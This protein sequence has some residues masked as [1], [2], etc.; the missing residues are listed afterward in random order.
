MIETLEQKE[1]GGWLYQRVVPLGGR[2]RKAP[3]AWLMPILIRMAPQIKARLAG[4]VMWVKED[5][6]GKLLRDWD[7]RLKP[8]LTR[9]AS[10]L[11]SVQLAVRSDDELTAHLLQ[12]FDFLKYCLD[13]HMLLNGALEYMIA[14][15]VF[16]CRELLGWNEAQAM[17]IFGG[18]SDTSSAPGRAIAAMA[19]F[20]RNDPKLVCDVQTGRSLSDLT[21]VYP[22]FSK[23]VDAYVREFGLR[24]LRA[25]LNY[26]TVGE[27]SDI[28]LQLLRDQL[29]RNT[30]QFADHASILAEQRQS[31]LAEA[32][33]RLL[34]RTEADRAQFMRLLNNAER[35]YPLR[36]E[37]GF[38]DRD[39]P[40]GLLRYGFLEAG[41]RF[42]ARGHLSRVDDVFDL[43]FD[44]VVRAL[45]NSASIREI[46]ERRQGERNWAIANPGPPSYGPVPS[47]PP[48]FASFPKEACLLA[49]G[50]MWALEQIFATE[51]SG[52]VQRDASRIQ[53]IAA[54]SGKYTGKVR[55]IREEAEFAKIQPGDVLVCPITSPVWSM[56]FPNIGALVTDSGGILSHSAIIA[57]EYRIPAVVAT[58]NAT[59]LLADGQ[60]VTVDGDQGMVA[61]M[62][63]NGAKTLL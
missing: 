17:L 11:A 23:Q 28:L 15:F 20:V 7:E 6:A 1:I 21:D 25:E 54:S 56:V 60:V 46:V 13:Q 32:E 5:R 24:A 35:A 44:E 37:H 38:Y 48:S 10:D 3:P 45:A 40:V 51:Q 16:A 52:R 57:R 61:T 53:G 49:E 4:A 33:Q 31:R 30:E 62:D 34:G 27:S 12:S 8:E 50:V 43:E 22:E 63:P 55:V 58:G 19:D 2:D 9:K 29:N 36:E 14:E 42:V 59:S 26:P 47:P 39:A 18:L 41:R